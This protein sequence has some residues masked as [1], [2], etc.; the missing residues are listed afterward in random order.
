MTI[1][2]QPVTQSATQTVSACEP[3]SFDSLVWKRP[4]DECVIHQHTA[5]S[6]KKQ[7]QNLALTGTPGHFTYAVSPSILEAVMRLRPRPS[8]TSLPLHY[9]FSES[10]MKKEAVN[11]V[12]NVW[13]FSSIDRYPSFHRCPGPWTSYLRDATRCSPL[14]AAADLH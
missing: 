1:A 5:L 4:S 14:V 12:K 8:S 13:R 10:R 6:K 11:S 3:A 2:C 7:A 9:R